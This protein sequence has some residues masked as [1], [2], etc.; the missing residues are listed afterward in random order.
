MTRSLPIVVVAA[1]IIAAASSFVITYITPQPAM[2]QLLSPQA[3]QIIDDTHAY[4]ERITSE[5]ESPRSCVGVPHESPTLV[6]LG[7]SLLLTGLGDAPIDNVVIW[8]AVDGFIAL[9]YSIDSVL[10]TGQG[11][12]QSPHNL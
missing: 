8:Q 2:A 9:G 5:E 1:L 4:C 12:A 3:Q 10:L 6:V 7:G 11:T